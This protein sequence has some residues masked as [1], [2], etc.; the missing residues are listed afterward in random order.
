MGSIEDAG[1]I[2]IPL[3]D[4]SPYFSGDAVGKQKVADE[5]RDAFEN[6]GFLQVIGHTVP[7]DIQDRYLAAIA[8]F[9]SLPL[10]DKES[11]S[12]SNSKC[13][14]GYERIGGQKLDELDENATPDQKEG[15]SIRRERPLGRF[16]EGPNQW[17]ATMPHLKDVYMEYFDAVHQLSKTMFRLIALSLGLSEDH[18]DYFAS[19][20]N[21]ICL[22]RAHHYPPTPK[23]S[24]G[25]TRG[26]GAHS[27]FGALTLLLQD[28]VGGL[29]VLHKPTSTWHAV[30]PIQGAYV[31]NIGDLMQIWTNNRYKST[32]HRVISPL[33]EHDR[34]SS[35]F[36][37]DG[38]LDTIV[39][40]ISTCLG[41]GEKPMY[42]PIRVEDHC[43][44]RYQQSYGAGGTKITV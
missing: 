14:R 3:V 1:N 38:A 15:F 34:Y 44:K 21:S 26:V 18:F 42:A 43:I 40:C 28:N 17:P 4:I 23:D 19:D 31:V 22:C 8:E 16:L 39:E 33:S 12:Q 41:P 2:H 27:D 7:L 24:A 25:R 10:A 32:M 29:E 11:V 37:N 30:T 13:H 5:I 9:F 35:A 36:F 6:Q 20:P